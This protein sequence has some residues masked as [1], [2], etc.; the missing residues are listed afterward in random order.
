MLHA[1]IS[2]ISEKQLFTPAGR[3][4]LTVSGGIDS[5]V[6]AELC[7]QAGFSFGIA[8]CNFQ[9]RGEDSEGDEVFVRQLAQKYQ[10]ECHV[11]RFDAK[12][13]AKTEGISTQMAA[14]EL[15]YPWFEE[16]R[17]ENNYDYILTAHHQDDLLET[18]LLNLTRGTGLAGLHG[19][20]PKKDFLVRPLLFATRNDIMT[21]LSQHQLAWREDSSNASVDYVR[22]RLRH[23]VIPI[24]RELNPKVSAAAAQLAERVKATENILAE[25]SKNIEAEI[26]QMEGS[27]V[28]LN[29]EALEH[30]I[31]PV[32]Y[33][34]HWLNNFDF[35]YGQVKHIWANRK[36]QTG[37]RFFSPT[38]SLTL[39]R[40]KWLVH[41]ITK[42][43]NITYQLQ[44][45]DKEIV[46]AQGC[47]EWGVVGEYIFERNP[48]VAYF[49]ADRLTF[50]LTLRPWQVGDWFCPLGM[51]GKRKKVSDFL[52]DTKVPRGVKD[53]VYVLESS[54]KIAWI[55]G[56][57]TDERFKITEKTKNILNF[58]SS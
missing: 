31:E 11:Q 8:H 38:Y 56:F 30:H 39:D 22:N 13:L 54:G 23:D 14:R 34:A 3:L 57:R 47:L 43:N 20:L 15:R 51:A 45:N 40:G 58:K 19:I 42:R 6:L 44:E 2:F 18:M 50:P 46:Y 21:F 24:L 53:Q 26:I 16:I 37:K 5:V 9:L 27:N 17:R 25:S 32:E 28:W 52:V 4:L 55:V 35:S 36:G 48:G 29:I 49:D 41:P 12:A 7:H 1:F 10:V 33:L